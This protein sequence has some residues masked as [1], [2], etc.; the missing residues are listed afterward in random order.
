MHR[1]WELSKKGDALP[2]L[3]KFCKFLEQ[4]CVAL[5]FVNQDR[6]KSVNK[7]VHAATVS[8]SVQRKFYSL[9]QCDTFLKYDLED[10]LKAI[11]H[12]GASYHCLKFGH[13]SY[14]CN[15]RI[16]KVCNK[17]HNTL[18]HQDT[19]DPEK[20]AEALGQSNNQK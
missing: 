16:C 20:A 11:K 13:S 3:E 19:R 6:T 1:D 14:Q 17:K 18:I 5:E 15:P 2:S 9:Y 4:R 8:T 12:S 10:N 7:A